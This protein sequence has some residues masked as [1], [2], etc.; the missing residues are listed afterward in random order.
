MENIRVAAQ[1]EAFEIQLNN[2]VSG[3]TAA[4]AAVRAALAEQEAADERAY[5]ENEHYEEV[6]ALADT[7][8]IENFNDFF[9]ENV[10]D[11][12][13]KERG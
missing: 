5:A 10:I 9:R 2:L 3:E 1:R 7:M 11:V 4:Q 12:L 8:S 13:A 6:S